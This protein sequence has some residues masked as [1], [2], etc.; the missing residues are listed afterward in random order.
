MSR[1]GRFAT[2]Q[3]H[4]PTHAP[5]FGSRLRPRS[6]DSSRFARAPSSW[7]HAAAQFRQPGAQRKETRRP[8]YRMFARANSHCTLENGGLHMKPMAWALFPRR[9]SK[10]PTMAWLTAAPRNNR[11]HATRVLPNSVAIISAV[12]PS[13]CSGS[14]HNQSE[15][16]TTHSHHDAPSLAKHCHQS[17]TEA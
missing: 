12:R 5:S 14:N 2:A 15:H 1:R 16:T 11:V 10:V 6:I 9:T 8:A 4:T 7:R 13:V 3:S 17:P